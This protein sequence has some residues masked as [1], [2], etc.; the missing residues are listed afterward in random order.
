[1]MLAAMPAER[2]LKTVRHLHEPGDLHELTF[3]CYRREPLLTDH[4]DCQ[5]LAEAIERGLDTHSLH[6]GA[7]VFMPNHVHLLIW[8]ANPRVCATS[9]FLKTMKLSASTRI[10]RR[11]INAGSER[12][13]QLQV[14]ERPGKVCFRF[15]QEG[16][17]YDRNLRTTQT[18]QASIDYIH[19][20]PVRRGLCQR[21]TDWHWSSARQFAEDPAM[22]GPRLPTVTGL[23]AEF[24]AST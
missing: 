20:N 9:E 5:L 24:W 19:T 17:C 4:A 22:P 14:H 18:V 16:S 23:P 3:S 15:W 6:L 12:V 10:K 11:L 13:Q 7:F 1:M 2:R 21:A 8:P